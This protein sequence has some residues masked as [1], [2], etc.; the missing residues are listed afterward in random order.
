MAAP[1][2]ETA[3]GDMAPISDLIAKA[4]HSLQSMS[5]AAF[6]LEMAV[7]SLVKGSDGPLGGAEL[8]SL[9]ELD[10]LIQHIE[11]L[12]QFLTGLSEVSR[13]LGEVDA[14]SAHERVQL[15]SLV[16]ALKGEDQAYEIEPGEI[17]FF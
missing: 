10:R 9:Q 17:D 13:D 5:E 8:K 11:G 3:A 6:G 1:Q 2:T 4:A 14:A 12:S 16:I 15:R 7:G